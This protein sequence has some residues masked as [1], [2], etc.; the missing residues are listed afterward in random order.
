M[1]TAQ[2]PDSI[3]STA[4]SDV[5][6]TSNLLF[7]L[8]LTS[9]TGESLE[10]LLL[11]LLSFAGRHGDTGVVWGVQWK[12]SM[13]EAEKLRKS[14]AGKLGNVAVKIKGGGSM[15]GRLRADANTP[16][17]KVAEMAIT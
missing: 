17:T 12:W 16:M 8:F 11:V 1:F 6:Q 14:Q 15:P 10:L 4:I 9:F 2:L 3:A 5:K 7:F 13:G